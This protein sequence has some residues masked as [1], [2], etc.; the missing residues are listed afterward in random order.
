MQIFF[1]LPHGQC[2]EMEQGRSQCRIGI[3]LLKHLNK[4][5][6]CTATTGGNDGNTHRF[7]YGTEHG[8]VKSLLCAICIHTGQ[9]DFAGSQLLGPHYPRL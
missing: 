3:R 2:T 9:Q 7:R 4:V 8:E 1:D 5:P 6:Q